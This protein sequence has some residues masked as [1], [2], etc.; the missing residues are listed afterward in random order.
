M[1][2][3]AAKEAAFIMENN[4]VKTTETTETK[5]VVSRNFIETEIDKDI[6]E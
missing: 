1:E 2:W 6:A 5:E 4:E 3:S